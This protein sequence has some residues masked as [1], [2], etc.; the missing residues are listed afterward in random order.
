MVGEN[1]LFV[2]LRIIWSRLLRA[3]HTLSLLALLA[4]DVHAQS[5]SSIAGRTIQLTVSSGNTPFASS[6]S[7]R[8]LPSAT[9]GSYAIVPIS[10][11]I[12]PSSGTH[13]YTKTGANTGQLAFTDS[14]AGAL[15]GNCTFTT[16]NSGTYVL[17]GISFPGSSQT[18]TFFLYSGASPTSIAGYTI[19]VTVTS[20]ASPYASSGSYQFLPAAS[21]NTYNIIGLSGVP[22]SSG[23]YSYTQNS[24]LTGIIS[25]DDSI[26]GPGQSSQLSFDTASSGT[27]F[28][29]KSG[30]LGFQTAVFGMVPPSPPSIS[31][32]PQSQTVAVGASVTLSVSAS[33]V[34]TLSYQWRKNAVNISGATSAAY[35]LTGV[36]STDAGTYDV[37]VSNLAGPTTSSGATLTV[38]TPPSI[39][40]QPQSQMVTVGQN[41]AFTVTAAGTA[42]LSYQ[43]RKDGTNLIGATSATYSLTGVLMSHTGS[44]TVVIANV[45]GSVTSA[46][47]AVLTVNPPPSG[48]VVAWG[49]NSFG[50]A[51]VPLSAQSGVKG[52]AAGYNH[53]LALKTNGSVIAWGSNSDGQTSV[54]VA[55]QSG[56]IAVASGYYHA[57][58]LKSDGTIVAWGRN[59]EG[60]TTVPVAAQSGVAAVAGGGYH[61]LALKNDGSVVAWGRNA[62]GQTTVPVAAQSG[63]IAITAGEYHTAVLKN[64]GAVIAWGH[65]GFGQ[66]SVPAAA[67]SAVIAIGAGGY[68]TSALKTDGSVV[69]WGDN[70]AGQTT[71]PSG[72]QSGV[73]SIAVGHIHNIA[74]KNTGVMVAWGLNGDGQTTIPTGLSPVTVVAGGGYHSVAISIAPTITT[75]SAN[76]NLTLAWPDTA[77]GYRVET[78]LTFAPTATWNNVTGTFQTNGGSVSIVLPMTGTQK[79]Y[80]LVKP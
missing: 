16:P 20:G 54:P 30:F 3:F 28:L 8:F 25:F 47:P 2:S 64:T 50:Q 33:G 24:P 45:V 15:T 59:A 5:P 22:N 27:A 67:Q 51:N 40:G 73:T 60:Q 53:T 4:F 79:F 32:N 52:I 17:T 6:G 41:V 68:H 55:A 63:V 75:T 9:D 11:A 69:A 38:A 7:Y 56:V 26:T 61:T 57:V 46:P 48:R 44:Y 39:T 77:T 72:A 36:Q 42:P 58:A 14:I 31:A 65:N 49:R 80:R 18:G 13:T 70:T 43:W 71:I 35:T 37:V 74:L 78:A 10:G 66:S 29:R 21:G 76:N 1:I 19:T 62:E 23:T 34:G 12:S